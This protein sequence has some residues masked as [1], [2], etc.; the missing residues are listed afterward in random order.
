VNHEPH[1]IALGLLASVPNW[2]VATFAFVTQADIPLW[3]YLVIAIVMPIGLTVLAKGIEIAYSE[4][5]HK[6]GR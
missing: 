4:Y 6:R 1:D 5:K 2:A 3:L